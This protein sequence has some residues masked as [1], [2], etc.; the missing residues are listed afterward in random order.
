[1]ALRRVFDKLVTD[2]YDNPHQIRIGILIVSGRGNILR[3]L[4]RYCLTQS[5]GQQSLLICALPERG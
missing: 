3:R 2:E 1:M 5:E 4:N